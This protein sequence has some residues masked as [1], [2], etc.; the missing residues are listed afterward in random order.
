M[1]Q[2]LTNLQPDFRA[3]TS[4]LL[5]SVFSNGWS[6]LPMHTD[7]FPLS[8]CHLKTSL[9]PP[10]GSVVWLLLILGSN[11]CNPRPVG[12]RDLLP[13]AEK[14]SLLLLQPKGDLETCVFSHLSELTRAFNWSPDWIR[15]NCLQESSP[16]S[17]PSPVLLSVAKHHILVGRKSNF[18]LYISPEARILAAQRDA[19]RAGEQREAGRE[20][21]D[22]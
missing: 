22:A 4:F 11:H 14:H 13:A 20:V 7:R 5:H 19:L 3:S 12:Y 9:L 10:S 8:C 17:P 18:T 21:L 1:I 6:K 2:L 15:P 16:V